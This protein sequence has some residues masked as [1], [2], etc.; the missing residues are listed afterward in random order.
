MTLDQ[1]LASAI[2]GILIGLAVRGYL[3]PPPT[4]SG[5]SPSLRLKIDRARRNRRGP[6]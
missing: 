6:R 1:L 4:R 5:L 3:R 2:L